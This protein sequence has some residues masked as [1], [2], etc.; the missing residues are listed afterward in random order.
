MQP[1]SGKLL[2]LDPPLGYAEVGLSR[3]ELCGDLAQRAVEDGDLE[4]RALARNDGKQARKPKE[5]RGYQ[6]YRVVFIRAL[7]E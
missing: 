6:F 5:R 1:Q 2:V 3:L 7:V 4:T